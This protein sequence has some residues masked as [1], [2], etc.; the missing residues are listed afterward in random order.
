[1]AKIKLYA[2]L[3]ENKIVCINGHQ[4]LVHPEK[5]EL[6]RIEKILIKKQLVRKE[7]LKIVLLEEK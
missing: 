6:E 5:K 3:N 4:L 2:L 7:N 1:M